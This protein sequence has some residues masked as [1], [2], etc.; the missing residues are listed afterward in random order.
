MADDKKAKT[1]NRII[2]A[3]VLN[4]A[5]TAS[6]GDSQSPQQKALNG[7]LED[8][9]HEREEEK[10]MKLRLQESRVRAAEEEARRRNYEKINCTHTKQ[11]GRPRIGGQQLSDGSTVLLCTWCG[12]EWRYPVPEGGEVLPAHLSSL[13]NGD[14]VGSAL[15]R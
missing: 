5:L 11:D 10:A 4:T 1:T 15:G 12:K 2:E 9:A 8:L 3:A 6:E 7:L 13:L 14:N